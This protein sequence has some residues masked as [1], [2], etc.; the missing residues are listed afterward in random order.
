MK[1][2]KNEVYCIYCKLYKK[3]LSIMVCGCIVCDE[4]SKESNGWYK[5]NYC[6]CCG[7]RNKNS[8]R[9]TE[10]GT[11]FY[12]MKLISNSI[13]TKKN[14]NASDEILKFIENYD[15]KPNT[16]EICNHL[17][18]GKSTIYKELKELVE[19]GILEREFVKGRPNRTFYSIIDDN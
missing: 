19:L 14:K 17:T 5:S 3:N 13:S 2:R 6:R 10:N 15:G 4:C 1:Q 11:R 16:S 7:N 9:I 12:G 18:Y 8:T